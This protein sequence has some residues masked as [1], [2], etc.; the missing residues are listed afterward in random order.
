M[1][2]AFTDDGIVPSSSDHVQ[3]DIPWQGDGAPRLESLSADY[4]LQELLHQIP[5]SVGSIVTIKAQ[6][7]RPVVV[8]GV[9]VQPDREVDVRVL[10][11]AGLR[12][13]ND[14]RPR[15]GDP[16]NVSMT[17][18]ESAADAIRRAEE[19]RTRADR[20]RRRM[21]AA[22]AKQL[23]VDR[24][25]TFTVRYARPSTYDETVK[26]W[27]HFSAAMRRSGFDWQY[28]AVPELH[29][30][31]DDHGNEKP[32]HY[33]VHVGFNGFL[34]HG[35]VQRIWQASI[36]AVMGR[37]DLHPGGLDIDYR[38]RVSP[39]K[40][41]AYLAKYLTKGLA[42]EPGRRGYW[43]SNV[44]VEEPESF[45]VAFGLNV[46]HDV[47]AALALKLYQE[48]HGWRF[49]TFQRARWR[50]MWSTMREECLAPPF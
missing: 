23:G 16:V 15:R 34:P 12:R 3:D 30:A 4:S 29:R 41:A 14:Y 24:L 22:I 46:P 8:H 2:E 5:D 33:H 40:I 17:Y 28:V 50:G 44:E 25:L 45:R 38:K 36:R 39:R 43:H 31:V 37:C 48:R 49:I 27:K 9:T 18:A 19:C 47:A 10:D 32:G 42:Q 11:A 35:K 1:S 7:Y 21:V 26:L 13:D 6:R 20:R